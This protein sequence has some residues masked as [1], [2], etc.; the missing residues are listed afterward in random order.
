[1]CNATSFMRRQT[2]MG[3]VT[4]QLVDFDSRSVQSDSELL[5]GQIHFGDFL[6][7]RSSVK[8]VAY[9]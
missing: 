1:M 6:P 3:G 4:H 2:A 9:G 5:M 8:G 7:V